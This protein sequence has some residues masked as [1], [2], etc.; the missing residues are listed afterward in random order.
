MVERIKRSA[1]SESVYLAMVEIV[2]GILRLAEEEHYLEEDGYVEIPSYFKDKI[3]KLREVIMYVH[4][5][6][7]R[8]ELE[9]FLKCFDS[10]NFS[11]SIKRRERAFE[12][13]YI[14]ADLYER[15]QARDKEENS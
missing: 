13:Y 11:P 8:A 4:P 3:G 6:K 10:E 1:H 14:G 9:E 12:I 15:A 2:Q 7:T 5:P